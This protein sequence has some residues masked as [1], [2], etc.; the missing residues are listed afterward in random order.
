MSSAAALLSPGSS[1]EELLEAVPDVPLTGINVLNWQ[2]GKS[3]MEKPDFSKPGSLLPAWLGKNQEKQLSKSLSLI[4]PLPLFQGYF[5]ERI[6][7]L[8]LR[9]LGNPLLDRMDI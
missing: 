4:Q 8:M 2:A 6:L 9:R 3:V 7:I 5:T 1:S